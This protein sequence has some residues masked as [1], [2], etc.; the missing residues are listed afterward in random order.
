MNARSRWLA[1]A[2]VIVPTFAS[3]PARASH[4]FGVE[5][6]TDRGND[7]LYEPGDR[8]QVRARASDDAHLLVY[9]IDS[10][11][12]VLLLFPYRGS[13]GFVEGRETYELPP[14]NS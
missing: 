4:A 7:A 2:L 14:R 3:G 10:E 13:D 12:N 6:W 8:M 11:G 1:M 5:L 9:E